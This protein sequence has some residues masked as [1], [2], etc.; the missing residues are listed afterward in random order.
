[1]NASD[2]NLFVYNFTCL[3]LFCLNCISSYAI[4]QYVTQ[5]GN[6]KCLVKDCKA[7]FE[8]DEVKQILGE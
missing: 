5:K 2:V 7:H 4:D 1:M 6:L 3:H 8:V